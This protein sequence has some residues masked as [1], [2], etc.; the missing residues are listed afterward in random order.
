MSTHSNWSPFKPQADAQL[1]KDNQRLRAELQALQNENKQLQ[2][3]LKSKE[4]TIKKIKQL[5]N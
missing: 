2:Q 4:D 3:Q 1:T 5:L